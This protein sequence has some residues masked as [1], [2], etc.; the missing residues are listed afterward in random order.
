[1]VVRFKEL[2]GSR[3]AA[4]T[5]AR[6]RFTAAV[7][8][9]GWPYLLYAED[10]RFGSLL[11]STFGRGLAVYTQGEQHS[12][13][14]VPAIPAAGLSGHV[15]AADSTPLPACEVWALVE[16]S[17]HAP[18]L[19]EIEVQ[20]TDQKG[21]F[22]FTRLGSDRY[23]VL[24]RCHRYLPGDQARYGGVVASVP[25]KSRNSWQPMLYP[26]AASLDQAKA[27]VLLPGDRQRG[28]DF[29]LRSVPQHS[30]HGKV[31][32]SDRSQPRPS[33]V[34]YTHDLKA[35]SLDPA[36][37][38]TAP[39]GESC[40][41]NANAGDFHCDF[42]SPG[43]Y[44]LTFGIGSGFSLMGNSPL[45]MPPHEA[46]VKFEVKTETTASALTVQLQESK[47][48]PRRN[49]AISETGYLHLQRLC[50]TEIKEGWIHVFSWGPAMQRLSTF[51]GKTC[52]EEKTWPIAAG[53]YTVLASQADFFGAKGSPEILALLRQHGSD[54]MIWSGSTSNLS[55]P[56]WGTEDI[57]RWALKSLRQSAA[58]SDT[59]AKQIT[60]HSSQH[61]GPFQAL[62][63][64]RR[65]RNSRH[66]STSAQIA[67]NRA[68]SQLSTGPK[69]E[70]G[71]AAAARNNV[72]H[73][74]ASAT[75]FQVLP[76]ESQFEFDELLAGFRGE[77]RPATP[78]E[79]TLVQAMAE[80]QWLRKRAVSLEAFCFDSITGQVTDAQRLSLYLRYQT[81]HE[82]A[83][84]KSLNDLLKLRAEKRKAEIGFESQRRAHEEHTRKQE[85]HEMAKEHH[86]WNVLLA[87]AKV[88]HQH[89][90]T[91]VTTH[92]E[93]L[94]RST[95]MGCRENSANS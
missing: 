15:Y 22:T 64:A 40:D 36:L 20:T 60:H 84:H 73:G 34:I 47:P 93:I 68:N 11:Q 18:R 89:V 41:W 70:A 80:H 45:A 13:I 2:N 75:A 82:R 79:E 63:G 94:S 27:I 28:I 24:V 1:V 19:R 9:A 65:W 42:L 39:N 21:A 56:V 31:I 78:T 52:A 16:Q 54:V 66:M 62:L 88:D 69:T 67:A 3:E 81:T 49:P 61:L 58:V 29:H 37:A 92:N 90:L 44:E 38:A 85:K 72:R 4:T 6:G 83:F 25:W 57:I 50:P 55:I 8:A 35:L 12:G 86:K 77:H 95:S 32:F 43:Y 46:K 14:V 76:T 5:D 10:P 48:P 71:K 17:D 91:S 87:E 53:P 59:F 33:P 7:P 26:Q 74:L 51:G 30:V 23:F